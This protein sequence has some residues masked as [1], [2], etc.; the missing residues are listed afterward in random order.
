MNKKSYRCCAVPMCTNTSIKTPDKLFVFMPYKKEIRDKWLQLARR[1]LTGILPTTQ[2][3]FCE[4]H[5]DLPNVMENYM[6]Y[7]IMGSVSQIRM[8]PGCL[9][10]KFTCQTDRRKR[11]FDTTTKRQFA[12]K[13]ERKL[14]IEE[15]EKEINERKNV[16]LKHLELGEASCFCKKI[17]HKIHRRRKIKVFKYI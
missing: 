12:F 2:L 16:D 3:Y 1:D 17:F 7:H 5:F 6:E 14:L 11:T 4:D 9:P 8:K 15:C 10:T 13:K